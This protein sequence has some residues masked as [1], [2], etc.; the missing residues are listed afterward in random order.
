MRF[1]IQMAAIAL[2]FAYCWRRG[3]QPERAAAAVLVS[4]PV[5]DFIYHALW[6]EITTYDRINVGHLVIDCGA[7]IAWLGIALRANRW[8]TLWLVSTQLVA[9]LAHFLRGATAQ[10]HPWVYA[11]MTRG[12]SWLEIALLFIGTTLYQRRNRARPKFSP[13][14]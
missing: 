3:G 9:V 6:G 5:L 2:A 10:M 13:P 4:M 11:A 7:L 1:W 14:S 8:W 12:P